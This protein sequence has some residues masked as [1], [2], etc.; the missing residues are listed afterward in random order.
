MIRPASKQQQPPGHDHCDG[1]IIVF[2]VVVVFVVVFVP[3]VIVV[4][5]FV[6]FFSTSRYRV[7]SD[8]TRV[9]G[10]PKN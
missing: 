2:V 8:R 9:N 5:R 3:V 10:V 6:C 7:G 4:V 1:V